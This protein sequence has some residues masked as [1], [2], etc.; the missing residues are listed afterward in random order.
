[1]IVIYLDNEHILDVPQN[2]SDYL[3]IKWYGLGLCIN[4][5]QLYKDELFNSLAILSSKTALNYCL[6]IYIKVTAKAAIKNIRQLYIYC[7]YIH[8]DNPLLYF[9]M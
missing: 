2:V 1:M 5:I 6:G 3:I 7:K 9:K 8:N 4:Y